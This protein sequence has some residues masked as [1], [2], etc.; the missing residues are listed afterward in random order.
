M[1]KYLIIALLL[2]AVMAV[3]AFASVQNVKVS[4]DIKSAWL[5]R[6]NFDLG[7]STT[8]QLHQNVFFTQTRLRVDADLTDNVSTTVRLLNEKP[9]TSDS[10]AN[11]D[12]DLDLAYVQL[13]E[14]L[15]SPLTVTV[16]RQN[17]FYG[18]G[19]I[20]GDGPNNRSRTSSGLTTV[21]ED[22]ASITGRDAV[23]FSLNYD[24]L[25]VDVFFAKINQ[26]TVGMGYDNNGST[27]LFGAYGTYKL[28][29]KWNSQAEVYFISRI[30]GKPTSTGVTTTLKD[31]TTYIP[32]FRVVCVF[33]WSSR[34]DGNVG[35][36][37]GLDAII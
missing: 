36:D 4:G 20:M 11:T 32:G 17:L 15:Y 37:Q 21:A 31:D 26:N 19:F 16:G 22:L 13:R 25:T 33:S 30:T 29:D 23:K 9:W 5:I 10:A 8:S 6:N 1:K 7:L 12:I 24:P 18:N 2:V 28:A 14:M 35:I 34:M 3:P 27:D